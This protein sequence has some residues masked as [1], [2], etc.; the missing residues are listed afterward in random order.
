MKMTML[1]TLLFFVAASALAAAAPSFT[2]QWTV[3]NSIAGNESDMECRF[4]QTE[5][6]LAG[7]CKGTEKEVQITGSI[8]GNKV[9]WK[10]EGDYNG[11]PITLTFK[12]ALDDSGKITGSVDVDP[13]GVTGDFAA[14][15][16]KE[17]AK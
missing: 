17:A 14:I 10:Y 15:H 16:S 5:T 6:K 7:S 12:G 4:I 8:D 1:S 11:T 3:H 13:F 2:G 9:T